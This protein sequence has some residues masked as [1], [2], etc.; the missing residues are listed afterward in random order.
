M[1]KEKQKEKKKQEWRTRKREKLQR[2]ATFFFG[3]N[4][5]R[6]PRQFCLFSFG[7]VWFGL[8]SRLVVD[9][10]VVHV[11]VKFSYVPFLL[12]FFLFVFAGLV[13]FVF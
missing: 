7:L 4:K 11:F 10:E 13:L 8:G 12:F 2:S 1:I 6:T 9:Q 3:H 5:R